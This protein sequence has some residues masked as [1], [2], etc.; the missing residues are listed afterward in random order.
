M[1]SKKIL[2]SVLFAVLPLLSVKGY[3]DVT[4]VN[5]STSSKLE[6]GS[7][8][9]K[10]N[11]GSSN[12]STNKDP[13]IQVHAYNDNLVIL[14]QNKCVNYEAP[15][16]YLIF[17][18]K[19]AILFDTGATKSATQFPIQ[20]TVEALVVAH[21]GAAERANIELVI[22]HTH[23]HGD[24]IAGDAQ[25]KGKANTTVVGTSPTAVAD[26]FG[27]SEWPDGSVS[28][29]LGNRTLELIPIPGHEDSH[30]A[31]YDQQTGILLS[32][33]SLYPGR[34]YVRNWSAYR[35]SVAH[36]NDFLA[37]REITHVL[38]AHIE[39]STTPGVDYT[40][41]TTY[42]PRE[43][44][45]PLTRESLE[46]LNTRLLDLGAFPQEDVQNDFIIY[47]L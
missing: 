5:N 8:D 15:F 37:S 45:L 47:P 21:Y 9:V 32:G 27:F 16:M 29:D 24:H 13:A 6:A 19:R 3:A 2:A 20:K 40:V 41:G 35:K 33:D 14:R 46:L 38:G 34:L 18:E 28:Y 43:H 39:M 26:Y 17:G 31:I 7:L 42:Q 12:C 25:F 1:F 44:D 36:L 23:A 22:A 11:H 30:V 4:P 10:W